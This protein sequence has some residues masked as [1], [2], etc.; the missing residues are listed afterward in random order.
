MHAQTGFVPQEHYAQGNTKNGWVEL[1]RF[2][3]LRWQTCLGRTHCKAKL[4]HG[5]SPRTVGW[6]AVAQNIEMIGQALGVR[7]VTSL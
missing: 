3:A 4:I 6:T 5:A 7:F 1:L 2:S